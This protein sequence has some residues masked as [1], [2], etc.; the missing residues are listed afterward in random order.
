MTR[1]IAILL[2]SAGSLCAADLWVQ[3]L[4]DGKPVSDVQPGD[5]HVIE[6]AERKPVTSLERQ[7]L[8][9][10]VIFIVE[11]RRW[12][13]LDKN[14]RNSVMLL[15]EGLKADETA[16][17]LTAGIEVSTA[18]KPGTPAPDFYRQLGGLRGQRWYLGIGGPGS[19]NASNF[20]DAIVVGCRLL[21]D[22]SAP[23]RRRALVLLGQN[24]SGPETT[25]A[26]EAIRAAQN[27]QVI[28]TLL[29]LPE[30]SA[31]DPQNRPPNQEYVL[32]RFPRRPP[33]PASGQRLDGV[34]DRTGGEHR[35]DAKS[36]ELRQV[37]DNLRTRY[38]VGYGVN[39]PLAGVQLQPT[40]NGRIAHSKI[41]LHYPK[42]LNPSV[43]PTR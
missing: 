11:H 32:M 12:D 26:Q 21:S 34:V 9:L 36:K 17:L 15:T 20:M 41:T 10:D 40:P 33:P 37:I 2:F 35:I 24:L 23:G 43:E 22:I 30:E 4:K 18:V 7:A 27:A 8:P 42:P 1:S 29:S 38:K 16:G 28:V 19:V 39:A 31:V 14:I 13:P 6:Q 3:I 25:S 5:L